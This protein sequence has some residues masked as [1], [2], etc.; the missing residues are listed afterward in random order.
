MG[1]RDSDAIR[2]VFGIPEDEAVMAVISL[3]YR[4]EDPSSPVHRPLD[5]IAKFF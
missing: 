3:G 2:G 1:M 4:A 5:E